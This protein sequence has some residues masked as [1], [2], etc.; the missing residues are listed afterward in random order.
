M[1]QL[2]PNAFQNAV[3]KNQWRAAVFSGDCEHV[4]G[5][6][7]SKSDHRVYIWSRLYGKLERILEGG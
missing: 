7:A 2:S 6:V 3:E 1:L 5:A 4:V